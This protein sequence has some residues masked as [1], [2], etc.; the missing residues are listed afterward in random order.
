MKKITILVAIMMLMSLMFAPFVMAEQQPVFKINEAEYD[1]YVMRGNATVPNDRDY[2]A[3]VTLF[4]DGNVYIILVVR[5]QPDG[6]FTAYIA[7]NFVAYS[8][9]IVDRPDAFVP[10]TFE[11]YTWFTCTLIGQPVDVP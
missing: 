7:T 8:V 10:D 5:V 11:I 3:R 2:Y 6:D 1:G 4:L 9:L